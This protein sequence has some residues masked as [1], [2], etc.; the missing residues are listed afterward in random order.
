MLIPM[1]AGAPDGLAKALKR[2]WQQNREID[3]NDTKGENRVSGG[4]KL[5][6]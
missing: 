1:A 2:P 5:V 6:L 3:K 4:L